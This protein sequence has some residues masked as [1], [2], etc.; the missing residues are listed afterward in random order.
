MSLQ[1]A[2]IMLSDMLG[3][4]VEQVFEVHVDESFKAHYVPFFNCKV[5]VG[6]PCVIA[7]H[8]NGMMEFTKPEE[9][10]R[11]FNLADKSGLFEPRY[12]G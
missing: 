7:E 4:V 5:S 1:E 6:G 3:D 9:G 12:K 8:R 10:R 2:E 11:I